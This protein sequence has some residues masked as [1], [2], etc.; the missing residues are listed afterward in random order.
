MK[1]V[2]QRK[3]IHNTL[4]SDHSDWGKMF[5]IDLINPIKPDFLLDNILDTLETVAST[6]DFDN[7]NQSLISILVGTDNENLKGKKLRWKKYFNHVTS[8]EAA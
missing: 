1:H 4:N 2:I 5:L 6:N 3:I 8:V 7:T